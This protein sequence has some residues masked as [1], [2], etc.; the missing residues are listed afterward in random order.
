MELDPI[1]AFHKGAKDSLQQISY[2]SNLSLKD[3]KSGS[4]SVLNVPLPS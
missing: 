3:T 1:M 2:T 4:A